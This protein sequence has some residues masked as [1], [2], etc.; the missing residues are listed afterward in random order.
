MRARATGQ[1]CDVDISLFDVGA[2]PALLS[3]AWYINGGDMPSRLAA[4]LAPVADAR[5][6]RATEGRLDLRHVH[7]GQVL[8]GAGAALGHAELIADARFATACRAPR[9]PAMSSRLVLDEAMCGARR[10]PSGSRFCAAQ[11]PVGAGL[12]RGA[13]DR[14]SVSRGGRHGAAR[15]ASGKAD[16]RMLASPLKIDGERP[17]RRCARRSAQTTRSCCGTGAQAAAE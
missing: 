12:R 10:R 5:A 6:D 2:A 7:E 9:E 15:A 8:G 13:G 1:G 16:F 11:L 3:G 17:S 4:Q 14:Q